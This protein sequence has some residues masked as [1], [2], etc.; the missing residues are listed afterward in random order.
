MNCEESRKRHTF[1]SIAGGASVQTRKENGKCALPQRKRK[2]GPICVNS[3]CV[4]V[5]KGSSPFTL[6]A[7]TADLKQVE[8]CVWNITSRKSFREYPSFAR[9]STSGEG[10]TNESCPS[11]RRASIRLIPKRIASPI[12]GAGMMWKILQ[13]MSH[14]IQ[15]SP[16]L[17]ARESKCFERS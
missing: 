11:P 5:L 10:P 15:N 1:A 7:S 3:L 6:M 12:I 13:S 9:R 16:S 8:N 4:A 2:M 14:R 17:F